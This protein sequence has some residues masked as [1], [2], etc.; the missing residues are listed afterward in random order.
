MPV[1]LSGG[2]GTRLWPFSTAEMPKQFLPLVG[3]SSLFK[4]ALARV[5]DKGRFASAI[6]VGSVRHAE[7]C[8]QELS[9]FE[10]SRLVLEPCARNTAPAIIMAAMVVDEMHGPDALLL[11]MPSD[12]VIEDVGA[13]HDAISKAVP[14]ALAGRLVTFGI[15][16]TGPDISFGYLHMGA[17][18]EPGVMEVVRFVEKPTLHVAESMVASGDHLWNAG[19]FL[20]RA[21]TLLEEAE[22]VAPE[23]ARCAKGAIGAAIREGHRITPDVAILSECPSDSIDYAIMEHASNVAVVPMSPGWSDLG[24]WDALADLVGSDSTSG[25]VTALECDDCYIRSDGLEIAAFGLRDL[26]VVASG[27]RLLVLP[28]G[29]SQEVKQL[30]SAME[31]TAA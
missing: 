4:Q 7:H 28:R 14:A 2:G 24:S 8:E 31:S 26:I 3:D 25:H 15:R 29:R 23:I 13:F 10:Q 16:P 21:G 20:F 27:R 18:L 22:R 30:L 11:V 9:D 5:S 12:H 19:I 6:V 1:V 17:E